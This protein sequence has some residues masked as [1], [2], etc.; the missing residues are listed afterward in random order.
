MKTFEFNHA[1]RQ[2][3][4]YRAFHVGEYPFV[5]FET[6]ELMVADS[7]PHPLHRHFYGKY[8]IQLVG[9]NDAACPALYFDE[10]CTD[11]VKPAWLNQNGQQYIAVDHE[12]KVAVRLSGRRR[13][14]TTAETRPELQYLPTHVRGAT[15]LWTG[16]HRRPVPLTKFTVS[17]PDKSLKAELGPKLQQVREVL[18]AALRIQDTHVWVPARSQHVAG[19][20]IDSAVEEIV[21]E[22]CGNPTD[23]VAVAENGFAWPRAVSEY[24]YLYVK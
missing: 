24:E 19:R 7:C 22:L 2:W 4:R 15:A 5:E 12:R 13:N 17:T 6:G 18:T 3:D 20:W 21:E 14:T 11:Y 8:D 10:K 9:T 1:R 23:M 16:P